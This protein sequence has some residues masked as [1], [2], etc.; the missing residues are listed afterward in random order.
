MEI[1]IG[2]GGDAVEILVSHQTLEIII[3][4]YATISY[5]ISVSSGITIVSVSRRMRQ[6]AT[7]T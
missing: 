3:N 7:K 1:S 5:Y 2:T 6:A 4:I